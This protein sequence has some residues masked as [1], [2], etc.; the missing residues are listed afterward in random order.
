M[1]RREEPT[2]LS[3]HRVIR[4]LRQII[5]NQETL[6]ADTSKLTAAVAQL[7]TDVDALVA[8]GQAGGQAAVDAATASVE[9]VDKKVTDATAA[10]TAA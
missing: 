7:S 5:R 10:L 1:P 3:E 2:E 8:A 9:A 6:M 4:L